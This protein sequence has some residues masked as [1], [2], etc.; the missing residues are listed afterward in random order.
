MRMYDIIMKKRNGG[1]LS[2]EE[3]EFFV[4]GYTNG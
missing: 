1:E 3:I 2:R 4:A